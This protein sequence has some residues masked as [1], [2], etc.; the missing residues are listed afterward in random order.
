MA[1]I[2]R[3]RRPRMTRVR[4]AAVTVGTIGLVAGGV[5][6]AQAAIPGSK[7][8]ITACYGKSGS[9][10]VIDSAK[11]KCAPGETALTWNRTRSRRP[12]GSRP[13]RPVPP[14]RRVPGRDR[15]G[16]CDGPAG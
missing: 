11:A 4:V 2:T 14:A 8:V 5:T 6:I 3:P 16:G 12:E 9:L 13:A 10:R 15:P 7:G 1:R